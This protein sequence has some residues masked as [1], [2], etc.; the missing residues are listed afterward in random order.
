[1]SLLKVSSLCLLLR[2]S[3]TA[4]QSANLIL[5]R[6]L[7]THQDSSLISEDCSILSIGQALD[8][9]V[10]FSSS[11][12]YDPRLFAKLQWH[13]YLHNP[14]ILTKVV[15]FCGN[16]CLRYMGVQAHSVVVKTGLTCNVFINSALIDMYGKC[17]PASYA[18]KVFD[19]MPERNVVSW[20]SLMY[21]YLHSEFPHI[22]I[23]LFVEML[24]NDIAPT[25]SSFSN[26][27]VCCGNL[28]AEKLGTQMHAMSLKY[29]LWLNLIVGTSLIDMYAKCLNIWDSKGVFN[30]MQDKN[31]VT[32][33]SMVSAFAKNGQPEEAI[34]LLREMK[35]SSLKPN[36]VTY[37]SLLS[38]FSSP[39]HLDHCLQVHCCIT[40]EGLESNTHIVASLLTAYSECRS[41]FNDF[42]KIYA[43]VVVWDQVTWNAI[44]TGFS[45]LGSGEDA[46]M[47]LSRMR[48]AGSRGDVFTFASI[49]KATTT[50]A[51]I[52]SGIQTH[53]LVCKM[54]YAS[55]LSIQ[56]GL[57]SMYAR[58]GKINIAKKVFSF[59]EKH[60]IVS[61][62]SLIS[63][64]AHNGYA[65]EAIDVFEDM[66]KEGHVRPDLTT[67][68][69]VLSA[70]SHEGLLDKGLEYFKIMKSDG[71]IPPPKTEHYACVVALYGR[72]GYLN[73]AE[74]LVN[75]MSMEPSISVLKA[76][77]S[78][79]RVH[80][81]SEIAARTARRLV[82]LYPDDPSTYILLAS[83]LANEGKWNKAAAVRTM[84]HDR[85]VT[86]N[87][88][89]S[90][91]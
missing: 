56:N 73:E 39:D 63:G 46:L 44:I 50:M 47:W 59:M 1:M 86:K 25:P 9:I 71:S 45:N 85:G 14:Y 41:S 13:G 88:G 66:R 70:C 10:R 19:E 17:F 8:L 78:S 82:E 26:V 57:L 12:T 40:K 90:W 69:A 79:C 7:F 65:E 80:G 62:N 31:I 15:S 67:F 61:W 16:S 34:D 83:T 87:P 76:L 72:A 22:G 20:N 23:Q 6:S 52:E 38:S 21:A 35:S 51:N 77:L 30:Q 49:L 37:S 32:W 89:L 2:S 42:E 68:L 24:R 18:Q 91:I 33:S 4:S 74:A 53:A 64:C 54:G 5:S 84:M 81:N 55:N 58:C 60:D 28:E 43:S 29:G 27:L 11:E 75:S 36:T 48:W 3:R